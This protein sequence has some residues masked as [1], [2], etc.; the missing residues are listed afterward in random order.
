VIN[1]ALNNIGL[2][3]FFFVVF[4]VIRAVFRAAKLSQEHQAGASETDEQRRVRESQERIRKKIAERRGGAAPAPAPPR[5]PL[6]QP[7]VAPLDPFGGPATAR[8][9]YREIERRIA[10]PAEPAPTEMAIL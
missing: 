9:V 7:S 5:P 2:L 6:M 8:R 1:W 4:S 10:T 3:I